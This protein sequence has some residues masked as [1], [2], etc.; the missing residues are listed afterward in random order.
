MIS[1]F[2]NGQA[3][4]LETKKGSWGANIGLLVSQDTDGYNKYI[5][6][7]YKKANSFIAFGPVWSPKRLYFGK[8]YSSAFDGLKLNGAHVVYQYMPRMLS[9]HLNLF[10]E[11]DFLFKY[12]SGSGVDHRS[13]YQN[14]IYVN[15]SQPYKSYGAS[16]ENYLGYGLRVNFLKHFYLNQSIG[17]GLHYTNISIDYEHIE[18]FKESYLE[19]GALIKLGIGCNF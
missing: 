2:C 11:Y 3:D 12:N 6:G 17:I 1:S 18:D 16:I 10:F 4:T 9:R 15:D 19:I 13:F 5:Y 8:G 14:K 7:T